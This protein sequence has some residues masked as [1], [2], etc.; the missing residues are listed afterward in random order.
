LSDGNLLG[1]F[2]GRR[3][4]V[5]GGA[6]YLAAGL[7]RILK[8]ADCRIIRLDLP[9]SKFASFGGLARVEDVRCDVS[10][11]S[12]WDSALEAV[13]I[14]FHLAAQT[15]ASFANEDPRADW[16]SNVLPMLHLL[17]TCR[18]K[19]YLPACIF[20]STVTVAG[21]P[22]R[23]PVDESHPDNPQTVYDLH[24]LMAEQY[25][26][27]YGM[28]GF[29]RDVILRLPN[30][31]GPGPRS[32]RADRGILNQ[33]I[34]RAMSGEPL[35]VYKPGNQQRDYLYVEDAAR[36]FLAAAIRV[37]EIKGRHF[38]IGTGQGHT[39]SEALSLVAERVAL[40]TGRRAEVLQVDPPSNQN[41]IEARNF[42]VDAR[43]FS[44]STGWLPECTLE[45]GIDKTL[46]AFL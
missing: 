19:A 14:V 39:I 31:Y 9:G 24:K 17:E 27:Y 38:V 3:I 15:S 30:I 1:H 20:S 41:S 26:K 4:L 6:G 11:S 29:V 42:V 21:V 5:S 36:A 46:E 45:E 8:D 34:R 18:H 43:R 7:V 25:L 23:L 16:R 32:S 44:G 33:M 12:T 22:T 10:D 40:K 35:T 2:A 13:D 28:Q 37:D